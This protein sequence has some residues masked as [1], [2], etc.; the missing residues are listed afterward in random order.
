MRAP[1]IWTASNEKTEATQ[2]ADGCRIGVASIEEARRHLNR[3]IRD[4]CLN[5]EKW[6]RS[7]GKLPPPWVGIKAPTGLGKS[8]LVRKH[9]LELRQRLVAVG[10]PSRIVVLVPSHAL[11]DEGAAD[12]RMEGVAVAVVRGYGAKA[13]GTRT[14]LCRDL[15]AVN[16]AIR[17]RLNVHET[18]CSSGDRQCP[19]YGACLKQANRVEVEGADVVFATHHALFS[20][21]PVDPASV[22][23]VVVDEGF[24]TAAIAEPTVLSIHTFIR[25]LSRASKQRD[26]KS[27]EAAELHGLRTRAIKA[28]TDGAT[29]KL[30]ADEC[31]RALWLEKR[32]LRHPGLRPAMSADERRQSEV[33]VSCKAWGHSCVD[34]WKA[35]NI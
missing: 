7:P 3:L 9:L 5:F 26:V 30:D 19:F 28:L 2:A 18:V 11:A 20:G 33:R 16:A 31:Q 6:I 32:R 4:A 24:W 10:A 34:F 22:A 1:G 8:T 29:F 14:R 21:P 35:L 25:E 23:A 17:A 13:P 27:E 15:D 12:W